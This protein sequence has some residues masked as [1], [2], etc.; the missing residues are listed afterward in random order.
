MKKYL[1]VIFLFLTFSK[2]I[3]SQAKRPE[4]IIVPS[5]NWCY[6][7]GYIEEVDNQGIKEKRPNYAKALMENSDLVN[8]ITKINGLMGDRGFPLSTLEDA[9]KLVKQET[10]EV[11]LMQS[12]GGSEVSLSAYDQLMNVV[13][14][15]IILKLGWT[16]TKSGFNRSIQINIEAVDAY[17]GESIA[18]ENPVGNPSSTATIPSMLSESVLSVIDN[19]N[20]RLQLY[21]DDLFANGR[22]I[23]VR[24]NK[25]GNWDGDF[26]SEY[27]YNGSQ[28]ELNTIIDQWFNNNTVKGRWNPG[29][30][31]ESVLKYKSVRIP[32]FDKNGSALDAKGFVK[33]LQKILQAPPFNIKTKVVSKGMGEAWLILGGK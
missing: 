10:S 28:D 3:F 17:S 4:I 9:L 32:M 7:N 12:K 20:A 8:V 29:G 23:T 22:K 15:D 24:L 25:F 26:E 14:A 30:T 33:P 2:T 1:L 18:S 19:F 11:M 13:K 27:N 31:T 6:Q 21:F 5:D 16:I